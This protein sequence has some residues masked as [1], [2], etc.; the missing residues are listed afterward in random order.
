[1]LV[2]AVAVEL[3]AAV[4]LLARLEQEE[5]TTGNTAI[6]ISRSTDVFFM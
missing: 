2:E 5:N 1:M 3:P 4:E 6:A